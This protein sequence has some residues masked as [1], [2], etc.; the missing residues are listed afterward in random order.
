[1]KNCLNKIMRFESEQLIYFRKNAPKKI[2]SLKPVFKNL[3]LVHQKYIKGEVGKGDDHPYHYTER[4]HVGLFAAAV[5]LSGGTALE[6]YKT[7]KT[8]DNKYGRCDLGFRVGNVGFECEAKRLWLKLGYNSKDL[9]SEIYH[10][11][12][13]GLKKAIQNVNEL[14]SE[15]GLAL[16]FVIPGIRKLEFD[17]LDKIL[18]GLIES[19]KQKKSHW[20]AL[21]WI[22]S[23]NWQKPKDKDFS[24]PG[25]L[26]VVKYVKR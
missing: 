21:V 25:L 4:P 6:E 5:W 17:D 13:D 7:Q 12:R 19:I 20:D 14:Q 2:K 1:V 23:K 15:N 24:F 22:G 16:C 11:E 3:G 9:A 26:L 18:H 10:H 8:K